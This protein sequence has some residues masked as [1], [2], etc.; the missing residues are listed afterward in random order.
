MVGR[1]ETEHT[2]TILATTDLHANALNY[3]YFRNES[4]EQFG[5]AKIA[6]LVD[7]IRQSSQTVFLVDN[8]DLIQGTPL[9]ETTASAVRSG[10]K[11]ACHPMIRMMNEMRYD[12]AT[13]GNHE[14]NYG[15]DYLEWVL[16][17][18][19]FP[20]VNS[21]ILNV[22]AGEGLQTLLPPYAI[23]ER[24]VAGQPFRIGVLGF[25]PPQIMQWD[26][27]HLEGRVKVLDTQ[28]AAKLYIPQVLA[29]RVD[30]IL[31]LSHSGLVFN[32][33]GAVNE[34][35]AFVLTKIPEIDAIVAGHTHDLFPSD[36]FLGLESLGVNVQDGLIGDKALVMPGFWGSHLGL[37]HLRIVNTDSGW[38]VVSKSTEVLSTRGVPVHSRLKD[39]V[40]LEHAETQSRMRASVGETRTQLHTYF[41]RVSDSAAVELTNRAQ[42][43]FARL[44]LAGTEHES[45][46]ILAVS[47]PFR[48]GFAGLKD[49]TD[50]PVGQVAMQHIS[51]LYMYPNSFVC[52]RVLGRQI[53]K[54]LEHVADNFAQ[55]DPASTEEQMLLNLEYPTYSFDIFEGI[56]YRFDVCAS[57]GQRVRDVRH[58]GRPIELEQEFVVAT[59]SY[60]ANG[61]GRFPG[62]DG[63]QTILESPEVSAEVLLA[64]IREQKVVDLVADNNWSIVPF[65]SAGPILLDAPAVSLGLQPDWLI[66]ENSA[67]G[68]EGLSVRY[69]V[70]FKDFS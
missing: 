22:N 18:A 3:D 27:R 30:L 9:A 50:I 13:I 4:I 23:I 31:A 5:L 14:F 54:W 55:I 35:S 69:R 39:I 57:R 21:N 63:S 48:A 24:T 6:T 65:Q 46:P 60:R 33:Q 49:Y 70:R 47:P 25:V 66:C 61:G 32:A 64:Y 8:G 16:S 20:Y 41:A 44:S 15:L 36:D 28:V 26:K 12:V 37:I 62:L 52:V 43:W 58:E 19:K 17:G 51:D 1:K 7:E 67:P 53:I 34:N 29:H 11:P 2:V 59:N 68:V 40:G 56:E 10:A 38:R 45:K 42:L